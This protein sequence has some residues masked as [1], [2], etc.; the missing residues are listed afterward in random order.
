MTARAVPL[1][2]M[3]GATRLLVGEE[4][5]LE[6]V[7]ADVLTGSAT[8]V[9]IRPVAVWRDGPLVAAVE[10]VGGTVRVAVVLDDRADSIAGEHGD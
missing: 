10:M 8:P 4:P 5:T 7:A 9:G 1:F 2:L 6:G 3:N